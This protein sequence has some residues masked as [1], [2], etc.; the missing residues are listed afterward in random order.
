MTNKEQ[1]MESLRRDHGSDAKHMKADGSVPVTGSA[2]ARIHG[3]HTGEMAREH[4][5]A[6]TGMSTDSGVMRMKKGKPGEHQE[7][8]EGKGPMPP[9]AN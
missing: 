3:K 8:R 2:G 7:E 6:P 5:T 9:N 1:H 4:T